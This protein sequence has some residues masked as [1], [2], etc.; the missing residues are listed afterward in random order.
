MKA[1]IEVIQI[2]FTGAVKIL[3]GDMQR[4]RCARKNEG[5]FYVECCKIFSRSGLLVVRW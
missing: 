4:Y 2:F 5:E 3:I 1:G